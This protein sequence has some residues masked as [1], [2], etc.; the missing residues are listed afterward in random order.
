MGGG[1]LGLGLIRALFKGDE[2]VMWSCLGM[3]R[4]GLRG[5]LFCW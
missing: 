1:E 3:I 2:L 4:G 5:L